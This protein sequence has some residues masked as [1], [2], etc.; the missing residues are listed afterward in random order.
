MQIAINGKKTESE[1]SISITEL[2]GSQKVKMPE[3]VTVELNGEILRHEVFESTIV[4]EG[5]VIEFIYFMG[6]GK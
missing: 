3:M 1:D 6:G 5:D 4:K 2:L